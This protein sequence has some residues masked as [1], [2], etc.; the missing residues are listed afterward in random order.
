MRSF[1]VL[2]KKM[3]REEKGKLRAERKEF[4]KMGSKKLFRDCI[5]KHVSNLINKPQELCIHFVG[6]LQLDVR[7]IVI[8]ILQ[9]RK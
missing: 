2:G 8:L 1:Q 6:F 7:G 4:L 5:F 9:L 3:M